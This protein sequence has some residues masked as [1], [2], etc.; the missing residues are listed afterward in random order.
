VWITHAGV[1]RAARLLA[2]GV[3][4]LTRAAQWPLEAPGYGQWL[5]LGA[6]KQEIP[7]AGG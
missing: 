6:I 7:P 3:P 2:D 5:Q 4:V 1:A